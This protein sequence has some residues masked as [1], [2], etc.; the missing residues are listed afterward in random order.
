M[1]RHV[2]RIQSDCSLNCAENRAQRSSGSL[3]SERYGFGNDTGQTNSPQ[4]SLPQDNP[5]G[6]P[7]PLFSSPIGDP[8]SRV[9]RC[10]D[11]LA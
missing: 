6:G 5:V 8:P 11:V 1:P 7:A 3:G 10:R 9:A 2:S 4:Q